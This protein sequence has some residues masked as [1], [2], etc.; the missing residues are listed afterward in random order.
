MLTRESD[1]IVQELRHFICEETYPCVAARAAMAH[2]DIPCFVANH[3]ACPNDD[4]DI[5]KFLYDFIGRFRKS[6]PGFRSAAILFK[7]PAE[8]TPETFETLLWQRLQALSDLDAQNFEYDPRVNRN[9]SSSDFS[10]SLGAEAF[11]II[12][13]HPGSP[14][15]SRRFKYPALIFN[16]HVQFEQLRALNRYEKLKHIVRQRDVLYSGSVNPMLADF[17]DVSEAFQYSGRQYDS[18]WTCPLKTKHGESDDHPA[19]K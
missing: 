14:R 10:F 17:G 1:A 18:D 6:K 12:G 5:L 19:E 9:P 4:S 3:L 2:N 7:S 11:F 15:P 8:T 13:L 16:P